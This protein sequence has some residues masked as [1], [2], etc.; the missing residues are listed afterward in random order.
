MLEIARFLVNIYFSIFYKVEIIN[1]ENIPAEG[2]ALLCSNHVGALDMFFIGYKIKRLVHYMAKKELF[3]NPIIGAVIR[4]LGA[5]PVNRGKGDV[6]AI[7][8]V[9][10]LLKE[11]KIVGIFPEGT[12]TRGKI[13]VNR[14]IKPGIALLAI[15]SGVPIIPVAIKGSYKL[16]SKVKVIFGQPFKLEAD[17]NRKYRNDELVDISKAIMNKIYSLMEE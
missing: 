8:T 12:R 4:W 14:R 1:K 7:K 3:K 11:G 6:G 2:A 10:K 16:F 15:K 17:N 5:F 9:F 13:N